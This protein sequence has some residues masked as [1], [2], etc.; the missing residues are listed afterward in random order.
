MKVRSITYFFSAGSLDEAVV[1]M[2]GAA[3]ALATSKAKVTAAGFDVQT[4]R[5]ATNS[6]EEF[7]SGSTNDMVAGLNELEQAAHD[8]DFISVG[9]AERRLDVLEEALSGSTQK[10][11]FNIPLNLCSRS[12]LPDQTAALQAAQT[13][14]NLGAKAP[15]KTK[16]VP[17]VFRLT[18]TAN[19][20]AGTPYF[21]GGFWEQG[22]PPALAIA[23]E[24][25]GILTEAFKGAASLEAAQAALEKQL[26][27]ALL[28][29]EK[30]GKEAAQAAGVTYAGIDCS[31]ASSDAPTESL[32]VAYES[33]GLGPFGGAGTLSISAMVT[34]VL[35]RLRVTHTGYSG[36]MMPVTEDAGL[37]A[38]ASQGAISVQQLLFYSAVCGTGVD[39]V[40]I[41]GSTPPARL[42]AVYLDMASMAF[43]L[44]KPLSA[45]L[46]PVAGKKAGDMTEVDNSFFVNS[47]VLTVDPPEPHMAVQQD[48]LAVVDEVAGVE[49][50]IVVLSNAPEALVVQLKDQAAGIVFVMRNSGRVPWPE[51]TALCASPGFSE[52][53][54]IEVPAAL[55]G[56]SVTAVLAFPRLSTGSGSLRYRLT[57]MGAEFGPALILIRAA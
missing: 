9:P 11:F 6:F 34:A 18:V 14:C 28:P 5:V 35:K 8:I 31:I 10:T 43:R 33:L 56:E 53:E 20:A 52:A 22:R 23:L 17:S 7:L 30:A 54:N 13:V 16:D 36:L 32:V 48:C 55:P 50:D 4:V 37:A 51:A 39:T 29:L 21:P 41:E 44:K 40:P 46:W 47:K 19:L 57:A 3:A 49:G 24:D 45:R 26:S 1:G 2:K 12:G 15:A 38:R 27:D 42:A 25:T